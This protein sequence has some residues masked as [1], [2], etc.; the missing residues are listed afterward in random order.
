MRFPENFLWGGAISAHQCEGAWDI[1]G[2]GISI[3]DI[4]TNGTHTIPRKI[5]PTLNE[6]LLYPTHE[7]IDFYNHYEE[8]IALFAEMGFKIFRTSINW[9][10]IFPTG[11]EDEPNEKGL[12]F[13]DK[14]FD[15]LK[16]YNIEP[17]VT[18]SHYELPYSLVEKYNGWMDRKLIDLYMKFCKVL[19]ERYKDKVKYWLTFNE[20]NCGTLN[21]GTVLSTNNFKG[22]SGDYLGM[23]DNPQ[24]RYQCLHHQFVASGRAVQ[25]AHENYPQFEMGNMIAFLPSYAFTCNPDDL[26]ANQDKMHMVNWFCSDVQVRGY[27]PSYSKRYFEENNIIIEMEANDL[28]DIKKGI[29]DFYT[30]SYYMTSCVSTDPTQQN[31]TGNLL[32]G[33]KNPYLESSDWGWQIDPKG[34]RWSLNEIYDRYQIPIMLVEN[35]LGAFDTK[36][37]DGKIHDDY[38]IDYIRKHIEQ[39]AEAIKDGVDLI[40]YTPWGCIDL[41]SLSTGEMAK[42]YGF[43]YVNKFDDGTGDLSRLKKDSFFWYQKVIESN[44]EKL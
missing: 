33:T 23:K 4:I 18:I 6:N 31:T 7:A 29:V 26:L 30:F 15:C 1:E 11:E 14:V 24:Q 19:F 21:T 37:E 42:R 27:Y 3:P 38:R 34:L 41:V 10:R 39:M 35:G 40:A 36:T 9:T 28:D 22:Y 2:K 20:I 5:E 16:K 17:L 43:I 25:F 8:D 12:Q 13:Y 32:G 44:G